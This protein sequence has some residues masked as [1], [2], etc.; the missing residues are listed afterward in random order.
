MLHPNNKQDRNINQVITDRL[1]D[2]PKH[3]TSHDLSHQREKAHL[4]PP[5]YGHRS[6]PTQ[7]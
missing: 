4:L 6:L 7:S 5:E 3:T 1:Q 2:T